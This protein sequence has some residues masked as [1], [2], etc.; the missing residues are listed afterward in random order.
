MNATVV[1]LVG[2]PRKG[3]NTDTLVSEMLR[4]AGSAGAQTAKIYLNDLD[5]RP[6]QACETSP[7]PAYCFYHDGM[8]TIYQVLATADALVIG[9]PA[10]Y[11]S[12]SAQLKL[13]MDRS[14]C[15]AEPVTREDGRRARR[16]RLAK[17]KKAVFV[18]VAD[19]SRN[20]EHALAEVKLWC[21]EVNAELAGT[22]IATDSDRGEGARGRPELLR[23]A[24][25]AGVS[26]ALGRAVDLV[27]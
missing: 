24:F 6:C 10:Y 22:L 4:G 7:A 25:E 11:L 23:R 9:T 8:D 13:V 27:P 3:M 14:N 1:G 18:W 12:L 26:L 20:P 16:S 5:I 21:H 17:R 15:L 2:S 19:L